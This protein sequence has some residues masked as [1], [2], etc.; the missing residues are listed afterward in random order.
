MC[1]SAEYANDHYGDRKCLPLDATVRS[2]INSKPSHLFKV[3]FNIILPAVS[4]S[5]ER[6][7]LVGLEVFK[8]ETVKNAVFWD[9]DLERT[10]VWEKLVASIFR[11]EKCGFLQDPS[12]ATFFRFLLVMKST[13]SWGVTPCSWVYRHLWITYCFHFQGSRVSH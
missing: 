6:F 3:I 7:L 12:C 1:H 13:A 2:W 9:V 11:V 4:K 10:D 5:T 8:A